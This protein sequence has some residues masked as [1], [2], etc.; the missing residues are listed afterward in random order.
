MMGD[1]LLSIVI[2]SWNVCDL[3]RPCLHSIFDQADGLTLDVIVVD[4]ASSDETV[5]MVQRDF[6]QVTLLA[7]HENVGFPR[8]NNI[9]IAAAQGDL[10]LLLNPDTA[11]IGNALSEMVAYMDANPDV[12]MIGPELLNPDGTHQ[13]SR[14]RF[15]T[16]ATLFF[17]STWLQGYAPKRVLGNYYVWDT[18]D[19]VTAAIDWISGACMLTRRSVIKQVGG[20]DEAYFM[21][22]EE[23]DWC[24]RIKAVGWRI[25]YFP[26]AHV[27]HHVG[28]SSEQAVI[29]R[30]INFNRAKLR[31]ARKYHGRLVA[32]SLRIALLLGYGQQLLIEATKGLVGHK[33]PL[34]WQ[35]VKS[36]AHVLRT[37]LKSAGY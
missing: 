24:R 36:Y 13:S 9:G 20:M 37:G 28:K 18:A 23:L 35:R 16:V 29:H 7:Q 3:L 30:H 27:I 21:Y 34:R 5:Q 10:I 15:P 12:G 22:S 26:A 8:G 25:V 14:R 2:V 1:R 32:T 33:R 31:Y 17:E 19:D 4:S 11:V 6:P